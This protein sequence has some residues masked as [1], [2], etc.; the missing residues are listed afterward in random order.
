MRDEPVREGATQQTRS[1][2]LL[3]QDTAC[4]TEGSATPSEPLPRGVHANS[5]STLPV[6]QD[7]SRVPGECLPGEKGP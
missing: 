1:R 7:S 5:A 4:I 3:V 2:V 6:H